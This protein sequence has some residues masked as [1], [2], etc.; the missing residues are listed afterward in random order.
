MTLRLSLV[1]LATVMACVPPAPQA[2]S[3]SNSVT[4][5]TLRG[6]VRVVGSD[7]GTWVTLQ[8][9][10]QRAVSLSGESAEA[11]RSVSGADVWVRGRPMEWYFEVTQFSV[12]AIDGRATWDGVLRRNGQALALELSEGGTVQLDDPP[13]ALQQYVGSRIWLTRPLP[14]RG[15]AYGVIA[16]R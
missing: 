15:A 1:L 16:A 2:D 14:G 7:P 12:R 3:P 5:D 6:V 13:Q 8:P 4:G 9:A 10:G 11:L